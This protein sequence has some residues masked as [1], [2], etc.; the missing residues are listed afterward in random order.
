MRSTM[1]RSARHFAAVC[2]IFLPLGLSALAKEKVAIVGSAS[3]LFTT[4]DAND[5]VLRLRVVPEPSAGVLGATGSLVL[6]MM[7]LLGRA[8]SLR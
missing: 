3:A 2:S 4:P 8:R 5:W 1:R 6:V 7:V